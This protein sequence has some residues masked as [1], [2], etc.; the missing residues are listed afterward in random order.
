ME[1]TCARCGFVA[2]RGIVALAAAVLIV[3]VAN[4]LAAVGADSSPDSVR[5]VA[6]TSPNARKRL[7]SSESVFRYLSSFVVVA[8]C[9]ED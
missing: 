4:Y 8:R 9:S 6:L 7:V 3:V 2:D 1:F 5:G